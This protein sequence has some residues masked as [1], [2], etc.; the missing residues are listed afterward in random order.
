[1]QTSTVLGTNKLPCSDLRGVRILVV[2]DHW[3]IANALK[4]LFEAEG[5]QVSGPAS[6]VPEAHRLAAEQIFDLAVVDINLRG[7]TTY[8]LIDQLHNRGTRIVVV[9]GYGMLPGLT[10]NVVAV[11]QKPFNAPELLGAV[12]RARSL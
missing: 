9:S 3:H 10:E 11:L 12:R 8:D 5:M 4:M 7:K 1:M 6:T 2:E